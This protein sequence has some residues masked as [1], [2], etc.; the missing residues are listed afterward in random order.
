MGYRDSALFAA[1]NV[2]VVPFRAQTTSIWPSGR[3]VSDVWALVSFGRS[4]FSGPV[5]R[6][7]ADAADSDQRAT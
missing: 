4:P 1:Q 7:R 5:G 2:A 3:Q 6:R